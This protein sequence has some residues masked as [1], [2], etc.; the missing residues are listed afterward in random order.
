MK[1]NDWILT[2]SV[3]LYSF[4]F[5]KQTAGINFTLFTFALI[6]GLLIKDKNHLKNKYW[7]LA[8]I[9]SLLS[10]L[11]VG[12]YGNT[13]AVVANIISLSLLSSLSV[14]PNASLIFSLLYAFV[15]Y[16]SAFLI[17][18]VSWFERKNESEVQQN[19]SYRKIILITIPVV[20]TLVFFFIY[21]ASN[22]LFNEFASNINFN[23][24]S[25]GWIAFTIGGLLLLTGF[26]YN[27]KI[28]DIA[29]FDEQ[30]SNNINPGKTTGITLFGKLLSISDELFSAKVLFIL[31]NLL[32]LI[33]NSLDVNFLF[34]NHQ[35]PKGMGYSEFVHQGVGAIIFSIVFA[36]VIILFYFRGELNFAEKNKTIK[37]LAYIWIAQN[38]FMLISSAFKNDL[39]ITEMGLTYKRIGVYIY[40]L[41]AL[42]GLVT[43]A[44]KIIRYKSNMYLFRINGWVFYLVLIISS[45]INWD[46]LIAN[47]NIY[48]SKRLDTSYLFEL[49]NGCFPQLVKLRNDSTLFVKS[50]T[51]FNSEGKPIY[52]DSYT[53]KFNKESFDENLSYYINN[54]IM[55]SYKLDWRSRNI[56]EY[57]IYKEMV[58]MNT[59]QK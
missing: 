25:F 58:K 34:I 17:K 45:F 22:P 33:V 35:L 23:F 19:T 15:S 55:H 2:A 29:D 36:I 43:T 39:Y 41:L 46:S 16:C 7:N 5:Y 3:L 31:L 13:L 48:T 24:I 14:S 20:I 47:Y 11:C 26:F 53:R 42:I 37:I 49:G 27:Q 54:F 32:L 21:R 6:A 18:L 8:A 44:I 57:I 59:A 40:L 28:K 50:I 38:I 30:T 12:Y 9:G 4:L 1:K 10:G 52:P 56:N 51:R